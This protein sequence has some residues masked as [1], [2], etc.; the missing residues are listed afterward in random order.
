MKKKNFAFFLLAFGTAMVISGCVSL[1]VVSLKADRE[2]TRERMIVV[3]DTFKDFS[4]SVASFDLERD[5]LY[6]EGLDNL[7]FD[8]LIVDDIVLKNKLSNYEKIADEII[9]QGKT[10]DSLCLDVYYPESDVNAHCNDYKKVYERV[11]NNFLDDITLYNKTLT[12]FND[13]QKSFGSTYSIELYKTKKKYV[14]LDN[15]GIYE[16]KEEEK[17]NEV[18]E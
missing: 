2:L 12:A 3:K 14:D 17:D 4:N 1:F 7:V 13:L 8:T 18:E 9:S 15:D 11:I 5:A 10:M 16:G 6:K